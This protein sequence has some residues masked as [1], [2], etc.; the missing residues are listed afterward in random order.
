MYLQIIFLTSFEAKYAKR[1]RE[2]SYFCVKIYSLN[3]K[4]CHPVSTS[5]KVKI[6]EK[7]LNAAFR[8]SNPAQHTAQRYNQY[9]G[10]KISKHINN[11]LL[12]HKR[13][14]QYCCFAAENC[15]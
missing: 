1:S 2:A 9:T 10:H 8:H 14:A 7:S 5:K 12:Q 15:C 13:W 11:A 3:R 6:S 4:K